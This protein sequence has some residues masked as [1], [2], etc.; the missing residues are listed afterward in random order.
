MLYPPILKSSQVAF[1][2]NEGSQNFYFSIPDQMGSAEYEKIEVKLMYQNST[3]PL[4]KEGLIT[5]N[6]TSQSY[7]TI[8]VDQLADGKW[9]P[10]KIYKVQMRF[11]KGEEYSDWSVVMA[12]KA[13]QTP[14]IAFLNNPNKGIN[15][16]KVESSL[17]PT[18]AASCKF[19][20]EDKELVDLYRFTLKTEDGA[21]IEEQEWQ[22]HNSQTGSADQCRF[23]YKLDNGVIYQVDYEIIS[24]NGYYVIADPYIFYAQENFLSQ[25]Q[26]V[27]LIAEDDTE[28]TRENGG[29]RIRLKTSTPLT[30]NFVI[31][32][33]SEKDSFRTI[34]DI[35]FLYFNNHLFNNEVIFD[36]FTIESGIHYKYCFQQEDNSGYRTSPLYEPGE[37]KHMINL[38]YSYLYADGVQLPLK[39]NNVMNSF[40]RT[41]LASKIDTIG[42]KYPTIVRNGYADYAEFPINA[43]ISFHLDEGQTFFQLKEDGYYYKYEMIIPEEKFDNFNT[44]LTDNNIFIER[45]FREKAEEFLNDGQPKLFRSPTEGNI[46]VNLLNVSLSPEKTLG[47]ML[48]NFSCTAYEVADSN[49]ATLDKYGVVT[50]GSYAE[51][52]ENVI[53]R[54]FGQI[55]GNYTTQD[56]LIDEMKKV[57]EQDIGSGYKYSFVEVSD[58]WFEQYPYNKGLLEIQINEAGK[59]GDL[60]TRKK[61]LEL[62]KVLEKQSQYERCRLNIDGKIFSL[63]INNVLHLGNVGAVDRIS[64]V[65]AGAII[66]NFT[67]KVKQTTIADEK[68]IVSVNYKPSWGQIN[69]VTNEETDLFQLIKDASKAECETVNRQFTVYDEKTDTYST[70]DGLATYNFLDIATFDVEADEGTTLKITNNLGEEIITTI[71]KT[72]R[73]TLKPSLSQIK[74]VRIVGPVAVLLN[75][76]S[77]NLVIIKERSVSV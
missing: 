46:V 70:E 52:N 56:N 73:Y 23:N 5:F 60:E 13:V 45:K 53:T 37:K 64:L 51:V 63:G 61:L 69:T 16:I 34:E 29:I 67:A 7:V 57:V 27:T 47:R 48:Y 42:S 40:K 49:Y 3:K 36:D 9:I 54:V 39:F 24:N 43:L 38:E 33:S 50:I 2:V 15:E 66:I 32:R 77:N 22:Q 55:A 72:E 30:G 10:G 4:G 17:T 28:Y 59:N 1:N 14:V 26:G 20:A 25:L 65:E 12:T 19:D 31:G 8:G 44:N 76:K 41:K 35:K 62:Q 58:L 21:I 71:G 18:F 75:Y 11:V 74:D 6:R 68:K